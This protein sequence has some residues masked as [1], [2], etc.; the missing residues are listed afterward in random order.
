MNY[1]GE[2]RKYVSK[3]KKEETLEKDIYQA[4]GFSSAYEF[5]KALY[6]AKESDDRAKKRREDYEEAMRLS[7][8]GMTNNEIAENLGMPK[9]KL[10]TIVA[11]THEE[12]HIVS[13]IQLIV[14]KLIAD[15]K[16]VL[17]EQKE[18]VEEATER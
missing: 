16:I 8:A 7:K 3:L 1:M 4:L 12:E 18:N 5:R 9:H 17:K 2:F 15:G 10:F 11:T 13:K 14:S 6:L